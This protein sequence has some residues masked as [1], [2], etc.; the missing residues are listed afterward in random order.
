MSSYPTTLLGLVLCLGCMIHTQEGTLPRPSISAVPDSVIPRGQPVTVVCRGPPGAK[1]LRLERENKTPPFKDI[2]IV[3]QPGASA[4]E[5]RFHI[6]A[7]SEVNAGRYQCIY[8]K[9][10]GRW[11][12]RSEFLELVVTGKNVTSPSPQQPNGVVLG[13]QDPACISDPPAGVSRECQWAEDSQ[14][15]YP[16]VYCRS[17]K[18]TEVHRGLWMTVTMV[19][20]DGDIRARA[21]Y[22]S[23]GEGGEDRALG[24]VQLQPYRWLAVSMCPEDFGSQTPAVLNTVGM[25][26][27]RNP[28]PYSLDTPGLGGLRTEQLYVLIGVSA[29]FLLCL[30]LLA[31]FLLRQRQKKQAS[32]SRK[33]EE[34]R[35]QQRLSQAVD[36][37]ERKADVATVNRLPEKERE[38]DTPAPSAGDPAEVTY[39]QLDH[40][41]LTRRTAHAASPQFTEPVAESSTYAAITR[42]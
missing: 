33:D 28:F 24:L 1:I 22:V 3:S 34:Q 29:V 12:D 21:W 23:L 18:G 31:L 20:S 41:A 13:V 27:S 5:A 32:P 36:V 10:S 4:T 37:L 35:P 25:C 42:N 39:A 38:M 17:S 19:V 16:K 26:G 15:E 11:S 7:F 30:L 40:W 2:T 14:T 8:S 6:E 9:E